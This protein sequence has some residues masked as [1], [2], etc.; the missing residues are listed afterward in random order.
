MTDRCDISVRG[1]YGA[2]SCPNDATGELCPECDRSVCDEHK[3]VCDTCG[4]A[5]CA[6]TPDACFEEGADECSSC[7]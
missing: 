5:L 6:N 7:L 4:F 2:E 3:R 1:N